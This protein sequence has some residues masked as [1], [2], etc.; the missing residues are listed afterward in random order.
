MHLLASIWRL[1]C[2]KRVGELAHEWRN[3]GIQTALRRRVGIHTGYCTVGNFGSE[4]HMDYTM[5]GG[6][7]KPCVTLGA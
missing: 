4:D 7:V 6:T 5:V 1:P 2:K 3:S